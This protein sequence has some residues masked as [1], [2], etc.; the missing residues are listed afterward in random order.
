MSIKNMLPRWRLRGG[1]TLMGAWVAPLFPELEFYMDIAYEE[2]QAS[3]D[4]IRS[5][6][7]G[8]SGINMALMPKLINP[9]GAI[10]NGT[11][12]A[13][14]TE[15]KAM[16]QALG[17]GQI[18]FVRA[19]LAQAAPGVLESRICILLVFEN[20]PLTPDLGRE[21]KRNEKTKSSL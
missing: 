10:Y 14:I 16:S 12:M 15:K 21:I 20:K 6:W 13:L 19:G 8:C 2:R 17:S 11:A 9:I 7:A 3:Q 18:A 5:E 4:I 1:L